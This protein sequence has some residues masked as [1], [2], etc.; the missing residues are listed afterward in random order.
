MHCGF[1]LRFPWWLVMLSIFFICLLAICMS[2]FFFFCFV[3][4]YSTVLVLPY[5]NMNL[6]RVYTCSPSWTP[7]PPPSPYHL[8]GSSPCT[9]PKHPVSCIGHRLV[10]CFLQD[11]IHVSIPFS[12][13]IPPSPSLWLELQYPKCFYSN[14]HNFV[15]NI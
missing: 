15:Y 1:E 9:S 7:L 6:P 5:I 12:Q 3:L 4:L 10:I 13:I 11:S 14:S 2:S 8:S